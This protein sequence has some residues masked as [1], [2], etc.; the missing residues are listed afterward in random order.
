MKKARGGFVKK[1]EAD[2]FD[3]ELF[4]GRPASSS[5]FHFLFIMENTAVSVCACVC[6]RWL[7]C[8]MGA[9]AA[10]DSMS[11]IQISTRTWLIPQRCMMGET[12]MFDVNCHIAPLA[13]TT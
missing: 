1:P 13:S 4:R 7:C 8:A 5:C 2:D 6:E 10:V 12:E 3:A 11:G 9:R